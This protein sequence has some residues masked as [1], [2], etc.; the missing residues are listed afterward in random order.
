MIVN[1]S[2]SNHLSYEQYIAKD[3]ELNLKNNDQYFF[4]M[5]TA[6][7]FDS[8]NI[9]ILAAKDHEIKVFSKS[10]SFKYSI[11][12][13][14]TGPGEFNLPMHMD[15]YNDK[16]YVSDNQNRR[17]Q[18]LDKQGNYLSGFKVLFSPKKI[19]VAGED[20]ILVSHLPLRP[21]G[22]EKMIHCFNRNGELLWE[23]IDSY[24]SAN[25]IYDIFLNQIFLERA[26]NE[27]FF[28]IRSCNDRHIYLYN[29]DGELAEKIKVTEEYSFKKISIPTKPEKELLGFCEFF[30]QANG[31]FFILTPEYI[32]EEGV[33]DLV[34]G[35][36]IAIINRE[37]KI[38]GYIDLPERLILFSV[39]N[40]RIYAVDKDDNL[41]ILNIMKR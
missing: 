31:K 40:D 12:K 14:G 38:Q 34:P 25:N 2:Y 33:V 19:L 3:V 36:Q 10:G 13:K 5:P 4:Y 16:I 7:K 23:K 32:R 24:F 26:E 8:D 37:G 15:I 18:I 17:I 29:K 20:N 39:D 30:V 9:F 28:L 1:K 27:Q 21:T 6:I 11:G 35:R 41:R 22:K